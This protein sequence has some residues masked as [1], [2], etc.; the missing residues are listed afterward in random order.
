[1]IDNYTVAVDQ[2][3]RRRKAS[4]IRSNEPDYTFSCIHCGEHMTPKRDNNKFVYFLH[5]KSTKC[6]PDQALLKYSYI[7]L[8]YI[9]MSKV[10][11]KLSGIN[12]PGLIVSINNKT[13]DLVNDT[14][15][16]IT[17]K[18]YGG[19]EYSF[20]F[21]KDGVFRYALELR[22][23][24]INCQQKNKSVMINDDLTLIVMFINSKTTF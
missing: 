21:I 23:S 8:W 15:R 24:T 20:I 22:V 3:G 6:T 11:N 7:E 14:D 17:H 18:K 9:L 13:I 1:M 16:M 12:K 10:N 4:E 19:K 2:Y 5:S